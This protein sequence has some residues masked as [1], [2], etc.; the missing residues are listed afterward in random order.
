[1]LFRSYVSRLESERARPHL[2]R[3]LQLGQESA[4]ALLAEV[5]RNLG[6]LD[7][8]RSLA[9]AASA[10][11]G[12]DG[13]AERVHARVLADAGDYAGAAAS[14]ERA[15]ARDPSDVE[16]WLGLGS[17]RVA[18]GDPQRGLDGYERALA[19]S[20]TRE[21]LHY[22]RGIALAALGRADDALV[23]WAPLADR[24]HVAEANGERSPVR[25][26][27]RAKLVELLTAR[28]EYGRAIALL[29][30]ALA[31][32]PTDGDAAIPLAKLLATSPHASERDPR[33]ALELAQ[34]LYAVAPAD[35]R[36]LEARA[37]ALA[38]AGEL[39]ESVRS[40]SLAAQ[41]ARAAG[42][43]DLAAEFERLADALRSG[44]VPRLPG[45]E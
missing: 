7:V 42:D 34:G 40:A 24:A 37:L 27:A 22:L 29:R 20:P 44:V 35:P 23:A 39:E 15:L 10:A 38:S 3:A 6:H 28:Q 16:A 36:V 45:G 41:S 32:S 8:A 13:Y 19:L 2:E 33:A 12:D 14:F 18:L 17:C 26:G 5:E 11:S 30:A 21:D 4:R 31:A 43:V 9:S 25:L 1:V